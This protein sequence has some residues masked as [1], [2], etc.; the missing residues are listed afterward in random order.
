MVSY[1]P[2]V[3][4]VQAPFTFQPILDGQLY[5]VTVTWN[6]FGQR[7]Y[8]NVHQLSGTPVFSLP[9]IG[10]PDG[11]SVASVDWSFGT[12]TLVTSR[13]HGFTSGQVVEVTV[14]DCAP[15]AYNG[16]V[17]AFVVDGVT[18]TYPL[19]TD[20]GDA[21][22]LGSVVYN[23]NLAG[24]YFETSALVFRASNKTFEVIS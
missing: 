8:V 4:N 10:S 17:A 24:G 1:F 19:S 6:L 14:S 3:P 23:M 11:V 9:L 12:V 13:P 18:L 7:W 22:R 2:F 15:A 16:T 5:A 21:T 20:P